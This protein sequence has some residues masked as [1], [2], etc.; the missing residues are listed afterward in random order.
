MYTWGRPLGQET[1]L[2]PYTQWMFLF[3]YVKKEKHTGRHSTVIL[4]DFDLPPTT[5]IWL[6]G[7]LASCYFPD[8]AAVADTPGLYWCA[9]WDM[10]AER[11]RSVWT[12]SRSGSN[13]LSPLLAVA[14]DAGDAAEDPGSDAHS[15]GSLLRRDGAHK[16]LCR[17]LTHV[18]SGNQRWCD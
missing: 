6:I 17:T 9:Y 2:W 13:A 11:H 15:E 7:K 12:P 1:T 16:P 18:V 3:I 14:A 5:N 8:C 10:R 4:V